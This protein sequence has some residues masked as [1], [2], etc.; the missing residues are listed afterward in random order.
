[1]WKTDS[2]HTGGYD[3]APREYERRVVT[4]FDDALL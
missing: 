4:F 3:A 1:L 2:G